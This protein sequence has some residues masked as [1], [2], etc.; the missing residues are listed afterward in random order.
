MLRLNLRSHLSLSLNPGL[1]GEQ[2]GMPHD[3]PRRCARRGCE[4]AHPR[5][6]GQ[7]RTYSCNYVLM[8][9]RTY[10]HAVHVDRVVVERS[11]SGATRATGVVCA[12]DSGACIEVTAR[13]AV[14]LAS[15]ALHTP[16]VLLRSGLG[17]PKVGQHLRLHPVTGVTA[18]Y[19]REMK[20]LATELTRRRYDREM[21]LLAV[22]N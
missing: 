5:P 22:L 9:V 4:G 15:G 18:R 8:N 13:R 12:A 19:D 6:R 21:K 17:G 2:A 16:C 3:V 7:A 10:C 20:L 1:P 14:V 11:T